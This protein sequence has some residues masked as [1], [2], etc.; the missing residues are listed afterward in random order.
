MLTEFGLRLRSAR[1]DAGLS[2][3]DVHYGYGVHRTY[4]SGAERGQR[5]VSLLMVVR[6]ATIYGVDPATLVRG[7]RHTPELWPLRGVGDAPFPP[8]P[9]DG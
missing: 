9:E 3:E 4:V 6:F 7:F 1:S 5:N 8:P 2:Q